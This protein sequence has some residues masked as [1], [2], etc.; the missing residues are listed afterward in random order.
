MMDGI[1][2]VMNLNQP[3]R[4]DEPAMQSLRYPKARGYPNYCYNL[5]IISV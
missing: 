4:V 1:F 5:S 2:C 3:V